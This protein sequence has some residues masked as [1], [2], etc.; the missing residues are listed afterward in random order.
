ML[1]DD[2]ALHSA[3]SAHS[4][5]MCGGECYVYHVEQCGY[6]QHILQGEVSGERIVKFITAFLANTDPDR[7]AECDSFAEK[8]L[9]FLVNLVTAKDKAVRTKCCQLVQVIFNSLSAEELD[10]DLLDHMQEVLLLRLQ[11]KAPAVRAQAVCGLPRLCD[12]GKVRLMSF[13]APERKTKVR[14]LPC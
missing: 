14:Q 13:A 6:K 9:K 5:S 4:H 2:H 3:C 1:P 12:P 8:L 11:D 10:A 7:A